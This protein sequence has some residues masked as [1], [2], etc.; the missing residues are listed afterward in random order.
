MFPYAVISLFIALSSALVWL[1]TGDLNAKVLMILF[2]VAF[3]AM[4]AVGVL[5]RERSLRDLEEEYDHFD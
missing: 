2:A 4:V 3:A 5:T 1:T